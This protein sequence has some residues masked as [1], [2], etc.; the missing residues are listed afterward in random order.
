MFVLV[1]LYMTCLHWRT[2]PLPCCLLE[3]VCDVYT[4]LKPCCAKL[5]H[6][7]PCYFSRKLA[8]V[9]W[10]LFVCWCL[11]FVLTTQWDNAMLLLKSCCSFWNLMNMFR[12]KPM[13]LCCMLVKCLLEHCQNFN[14][15]WWNSYHVIVYCCSNFVL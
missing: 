3:F 2:L 9:C 12:K 7:E 15:A 13:W 5:C 11:K 1:L 8:H 10:L 4:M 14:A 6:D